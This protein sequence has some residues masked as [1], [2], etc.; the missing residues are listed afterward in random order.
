MSSVECRS[1]LPA[2][3]KQASPTLSP[4]TQ[5]DDIATLGSTAAASGDNPGVSC[6]LLLLLLACSRVRPLCRRR[7]RKEHS[8]NIGLDTRKTPGCLLSAAKI[9]LSVPQLSCSSILPNNKMCVSST[10]AYNDGPASNQRSV[11]SVLTATS[12]CSSGRPCRQDEAGSRGGAKV[13][14]ATG[15]KKRGDRVTKRRA[16]RQ[17]GARISERA[18]GMQA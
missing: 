6:E 13:L 4:P 9:F 2:R 17:W 10:G 14:P 15:G 12:A 3:Q 11:P 16:S 1:C 5:L 18:G 8:V 7:T